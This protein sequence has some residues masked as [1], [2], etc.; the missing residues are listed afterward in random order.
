MIMKLGIFRKILLC[1][2]DVVSGK[3]LC[4]S[5]MIL[6]NHNEIPRISD[7]SGKILTSLS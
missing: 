6:S 2:E 1:H 3:S 7:S 4:H 5:I